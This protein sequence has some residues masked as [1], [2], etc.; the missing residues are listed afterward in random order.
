M[1]GS[2]TNCLRNSIDLIHKMAFQYMGPFDLRTYIWKVYSIIKNVRLVQHVCSVSIHF[3][4]DFPFGTSVTSP[5]GL[6][7]A[8]T[9][10]FL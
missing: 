4:S 2:G 8:C 9:A 5:S 1:P 7:K 10:F 6:S 3:H